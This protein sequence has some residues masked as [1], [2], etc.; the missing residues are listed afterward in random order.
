MKETA[1]T[2]RQGQSAGNLPHS[3]AHP[4]P[5]ESAL[6]KLPSTSPP[7]PPHD[8]SCSANSTRENVPYTPTPTPPIQP[9]HTPTPRSSSRRGESREKIT[10]IPEAA[11][12]ESEGSGE[13][14]AGD[15]ITVVEDGG[16]EEGKEGRGKGS[17]HP[18]VS[19]LVDVALVTHC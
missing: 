7:P 17:A 13:Q 8:S 16:R 6:N 11:A 2:N 3:L 10:E 5:A 1:Q 19:D 14:K 9:N 18:S 4:N 12:A 15:S